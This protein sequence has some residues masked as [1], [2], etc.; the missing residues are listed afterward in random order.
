MEEKELATTEKPSEL[1]A[2]GKDN[3]Q[4][5]MN[6]VSQNNW[7]IQI[8]GKKYLQ[9][10]AWQ[11]LAKFYGLS[12]RTVSTTFVEYG[13]IKGFEARAE[14][15]DKEGKIVGAGEGACL[16]DEKQW[17]G[18]PLFSLK[19]M[20][21]TRASGR[22][23][24]QMLSWVA[25]LAGYQPTAVEEMPKDILEVDPIKAKK[26]EVVYPAKQGCTHGRSEVFVTQNGKNA[27]RKYEKCL[28]CNSF[29][30]WVKE[31]TLSDDD[32]LEAE[33]MNI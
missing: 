19:A 6:I 17:I 27:G 8:Q 31:E 1:V 10:E 18:K 14:V 20:A 32:I 11:T 23:L 30:K 28:D 22:A 9:F 29:L 16:T 24:R 15:V 5:L 33:E 26:E 2:Q 7:A 25:V 4:V 12:V 13:T 3:A 21:Q